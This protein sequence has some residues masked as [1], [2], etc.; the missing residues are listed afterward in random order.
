[1]NKQGASILVVDDK[2]EIVRALQHS[3]GAHGYRVLTATNGN[4]ALAMVFQQ[5]PDLVVLDLMMPGVSGLEVCRQ[6]RATSNLPIIVL[7]VK[8]AEH[9]KV[10]ALDLGAGAWRK[11]QRRTG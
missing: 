8:D 4:D 10:E 2:R 9:D 6:V 11:Q 7:S 1:M 5:R 3:L